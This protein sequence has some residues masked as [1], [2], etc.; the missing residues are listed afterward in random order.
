MVLLLTTACGGLDSVD[1]S[2]TN[3]RRIDCDARTPAL[4][5]DNFAQPF[6]SKN[7]TGCHHSEVKGEDRKGAPA[8]IDLN[9]FDDVQTWGYIVHARTLGDEPT[10]PPGGGLTADESLRLEEW[11]QCDLLSDTL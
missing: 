2:S 8:G 1:N 10:M 4:S 7:C 6:M 9:T 5:Y 11:L 3:S